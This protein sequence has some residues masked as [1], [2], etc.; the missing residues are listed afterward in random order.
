M[1]AEGFESLCNGTEKYADENPLSALYTSTFEKELRYYFAV[2]GMPEAVLSW[3][4]NHNISEVVQIQ[5]TILQDYESDFSKHAPIT[6]VAKIG[7]IWDSIPAQLAKDNKKF[8]FFACKSQKTF[9]R[10]RGRA[11]VACRSR[12]CL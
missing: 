11:H 8:I 3:S 12:S 5:N 7:W 1:W 4:K 10:F 6:D 2:G 9:C